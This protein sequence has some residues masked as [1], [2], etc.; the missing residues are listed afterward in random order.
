MEYDKPA[1]SN[2]LHVGRPNIGNREHFISRVNT[3]LDNAWLTNHGP[4]VQE[5]EQRL[6]EYL[7]VKHC[8]TTCNGT[9]AL[10]LAIRALDLSGEVIV[11][12]FTFVATA[13]ALQWHRI[14]PVFCDIHPQTYHIDPGEIERHITSQTTG[15]V[16]VHMY[17]HPCDIQA[18]Q[19]LA[20][21]HNLKV[22]YDAAHAFGC[23]YGGRMIGNFGDCEIFSFNA[24]KFFNTFEGGAVAT[25]NDALAQEI[26]LMQRFGFQGHDHVISIGINGKM[27]EVSAAMGLTNLED[28]DTFM[29]RNKRNYQHYYQGFETIAGLTLQELDTSERGNGQYVVVEVGDEYPLSRDELLAKLHAENVLVRRYFWPGCHKMEPYCSMFLQAGD[30]LPITEEKAARVLVFPTGMAISQTEIDRIIM[31]CQ[32]K[33]ES[34]SA[35]S[36]VSTGSQQKDKEGSCV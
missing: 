28:L 35:I 10:E 30:Y 24:T 13:H 3:I 15:I 6:S 4:F 31:L 29:E 7:G 25:N 19:D 21:R 9:M 36:E 27:N 5:F 8:I 32:R 23:S 33:T 11:P 34:L 12:S 20:H 14:K 16:G 17:G 26:R 22:L 18:I 1:F 2:P